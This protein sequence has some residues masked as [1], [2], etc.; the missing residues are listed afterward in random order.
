MCRPL[1]PAPPDWY[2]IPCT[3]LT[4][5][6]EL[7]CIPIGRGAGYCRNSTVMA[8]PNG[9]GAARPISKMPFAS[10][11]TAAGQGQT[12]PFLLRPCR[13]HPGRRLL[14]LL[15][16]R[17]PFPLR[18]RN[19]LARRSTHRPLRS[20]PRPIR[21]ADRGTHRAPAKLPPQLCDLLV[22]L[23]SGNRKASRCRSPR[24]TGQCIGIGRRE[25]RRC[26]VRSA[27]CANR[28]RSIAARRR[29][30]WEAPRDW[31]W[32]RP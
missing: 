18:S 5:T 30:R 28:S 13:L 27:R 32:H 16:C 22:D 29:R 19:A 24:Q 6:S 12:C 8:G 25:T 4:K 26:G 1:A 9:A 23:T 31:W 14:R 21:A 11:A 17:P 7:R 3:V 10:R 15:V 20:R 2:T